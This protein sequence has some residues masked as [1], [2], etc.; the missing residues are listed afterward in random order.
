MFCISPEKA[1]ITKEKRYGDI[2][3]P[4]RKPLPPEK[5]PHSSPLMLIE[6]LDVEMHFWEMKVTS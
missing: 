2:G 5:N 4:W 1:S 6:N 3:S